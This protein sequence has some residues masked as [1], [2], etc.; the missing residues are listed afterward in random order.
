MNYII[1]GYNFLF[2]LPVNKKNS[3]ENRRNSLLEILQ[4]EL[5]HFAGP[6]AIV[7]DSGEQICDYAQKAQMAHLEVI[8]APCNKTA[9]EYIIELVE[10]K[11]SPKTTTVVTSDNDLAR[12]CG[13]HGA[14]SLTIEEFLALVEKR[15]KTKAP[16]ET[17]SEAVAPGQMQRWLEIFEQRLKDQD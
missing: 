6:I 16:A 2:R 3:L 9:D 4:Q 10:N 7:F 8:Y 11:K 12:Q 17:K 14:K 15:N 1:D 13:Y 5:I